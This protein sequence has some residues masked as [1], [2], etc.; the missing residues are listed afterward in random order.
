MK[1]IYHSSD[2]HKYDIARALTGNKRSTGKAAEIRSVTQIYTEH[3]EYAY[4]RTNKMPAQNRCSSG[5]TES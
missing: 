2:E 1:L 4:R 3:K 5:K